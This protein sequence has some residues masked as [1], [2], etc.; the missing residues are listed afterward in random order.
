MNHHYAPPIGAAHE[1]GFSLPACGEDKEI[2]Q[3]CYSVT[4]WLYRV[5]Y[6]IYASSEIKKFFFALLENKK[7]F[8]KPKI[9]VLWHQAVISLWFLIKMLGLILY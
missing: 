1:P 5:L 6:L 4:F 8:V 7:L 3:F 2:K 9:V